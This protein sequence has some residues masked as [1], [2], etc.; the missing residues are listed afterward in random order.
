MNNLTTADISDSAGAQM[1]PD[2]IRKRWP[3]V[4]HRFA[5]GAYDRRALTDKVAYKGCIIEVVAAST[6]S[7]FPSPAAPRWM[8]N[9]P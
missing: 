2:Q 1:I 8:V 3:W 4:K 9:A 6:D 7:G 5:A